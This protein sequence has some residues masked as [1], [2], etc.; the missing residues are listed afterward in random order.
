M[1][2][3]V[4][5][6]KHNIIAEFEKTALNNSI[7]L[8]GDVE[9]KLVAPEIICV[10][11]NKPPRGPCFDHE[12]RVILLHES[13]LAFLWAYIYSQFVIFEENVRLPRTQGKNPGV[14]KFD[15]PLLC[16]AKSL[17]QWA[18]QFSRSYI[19]W[20]M[21]ALPNPEKLDASDATEK[22]YIEQANSVFCRA[23]AFL[24]LHEYAHAVLKHVPQGTDLYLLD[25]EKE[26][27]NY[28]LDQIAFISS[29][30]DEK[31]R[32]GLSL[33]MLCSSS[34]F[35]I[36]ESRN[37]WQR[38]HPDLHERVRHAIVQLDLQLERMKDDIY[39][40]ASIAVHAFLA[41]HGNQVGQLVENTGEELFFTYLGLVDGLKEP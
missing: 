33:V 39:Y 38:R 26:A 36:N 6:L 25:Q 41:K 14:I 18:M 21:D 19:P 7:C 8:S 10:V 28:A 4:K 34:L 5:V 20:D 12:K 30:E 35:L 31:W 3:P 24:L 22:K 9:K 23:V 40:L 17:E 37:V 16:R 11:D 13:Y 1:H 2:L 29:S 15:T 27:D 32:S